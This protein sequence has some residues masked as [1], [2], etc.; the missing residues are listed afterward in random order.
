MRNPADSTTTQE[1]WQRRPAFGQQ[2]HRIECQPREGAVVFRCEA[3]DR[4]IRD[5]RAVFLAH[6]PVTGW[7]IECARHPDAEYAVDGGH[8]F[9]G[10]LHAVDL[11][12]DLA[13]ARWF[14]AAELF[15]AVTRLRAQ[16]RGVYR[17][18]GGGD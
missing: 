16:S 10:G 7:R 17:R 5:L 12:A 2:S 4:E 3:C 9:G 8:L 1:A 11:L 6:R 15:N 14:V 18:A 13:R